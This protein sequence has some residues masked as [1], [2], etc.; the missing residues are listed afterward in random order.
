MIDPIKSQQ[1]ADAVF[2]FLVTG[3]MDVCDIDREQAEKRIRKL[4]DSGI[5][6]GEHPAHPEMRK[7][8]NEFMRTPVE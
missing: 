4:L 8:I 6:D 1:E 5:L 2:E 7:K 3:A